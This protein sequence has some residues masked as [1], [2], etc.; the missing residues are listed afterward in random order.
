MM[1]PSFITKLAHP[2]YGDHVL[3]HAYDL[4]PGATTFRAWAFNGWR[5]EKSV[6]AKRMLHTRRFIA[7]RPDLDQRPRGEEI[8]AKHLDQ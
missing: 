1:D 5:K 4:R 3:Y 8:L 2:F 6:L 7:R